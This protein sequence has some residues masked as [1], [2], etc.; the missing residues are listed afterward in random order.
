M[1]HQPGHVLHVARAGNRNFGRGPGPGP[2]T[3][4]LFVFVL[5]IL[6]ELTLTW[7][8]ERETVSAVYNNVN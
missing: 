5:L 4:K 3:R 7:A 2:G 1:T 6:F 8:G